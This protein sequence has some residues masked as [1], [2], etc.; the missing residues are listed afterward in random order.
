ME[1]KK[2]NY[3]VNYY[4]N[5][6]GRNKAAFLAFVLLLGASSCKDFVEEDISDKS[7]QMIIPTAND[8]IESN[9]VHFKWEE[10]EGADNY[11]IQLVSSSF[12]NLNTFILDSLISG[13]EYYYSLNPGE[14]EFKIR[15]ENS[16]YESNY[17][18]PY[19]FVVDSVS[20]LGGQTVPLISPA[21]AIYSN[22]LDLTLNWQTIFAAETYEVQ[23]RSGN[24]FDNSPTILQTATGIYGSSYTT[25]GNTFFNEGQYSWGVRAINSSSQ[26]N[27]SS[28]V[29]NIDATN[30][31]DVSLTSPADAFNNL[32]DTVVFK[33]SSGVDPGTVNSPLTYEFEL[34]NN[35]G[36]SSPAI[37]NP[38]ADSL[39]LILSSGTH[40][41][42]VY[43]KD[44]AG[45]QSANYSS[46]YS[47]VIP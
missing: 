2:K 6:I 35:A 32:D 7:V 33:W 14:Y 31:N 47:I 10:L 13:T 44:E 11:R 28:R 25:T 4:F 12:T 42:R 15:G 38:T 23:V 3:M 39:Q 17:A 37:Y 30:P 46:E 27:Y 8:T 40:Y 41:W 16:A 29:I 34:A 24:D 5:T 45:N 19:A 9:V 21:D 1:V 36:F 18:G 43:A 26:S 22:A 20:D